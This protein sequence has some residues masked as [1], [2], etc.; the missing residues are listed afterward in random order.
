MDLVSPDDALL[1][2]LLVEPGG[3]LVRDQLEVAIVSFRQTE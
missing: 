3:P 1:L 2:G